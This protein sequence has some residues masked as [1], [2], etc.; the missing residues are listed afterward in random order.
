MKKGDTA[1]SIQVS[2][3]TNIKLKENCNY[4]RTK[5]KWIRGVGL[6]VEVEKCDSNVINELELLVIFPVAPKSMAHLEE[7]K[8]KHLL[9]LPTMAGIGI[10]ICEQLT[11]LG[12]HWQTQC[13]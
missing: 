10:L 3:L 9:G 13:K 5:V 11:F 2:L 8:I 12:H 6:I 7:E 4:L 1:V